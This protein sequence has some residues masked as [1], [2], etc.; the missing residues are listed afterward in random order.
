MALQ[1]VF[2]ARATDSNRGSTIAQFIRSGS[3]NQTASVE[4]HIRNSSHLPWQPPQLGRK[5]FTSRLPSI[6]RLRRDIVGNAA[7]TSA[8]S[9]YA[10]YYDDAWH[11][12]SADDVQQ[13]CQ[14]FNIQVSN[15][16]VILTQERSKRFLASGSHEDKYTFFFQ[17]TML[18]KLQ[19]KHEEGDRRIAAMVQE[20]SGGAESLKRMVKERDA[21]EEWVQRKRIKDEAEAAVREMRALESWARW[22]ERADQRDKQQTTAVGLKLEMERMKGELE[23]LEAD[24]GRFE[25][26][27]RKRKEEV[28]ARVRAYE[29][30]KDSVTDA[31]RQVEAQKAKARAAEN[32][33]DAVQKR[34][35]RSQ[36]ELQRKTAEVAAVR[37]E[38]EEQNAHVE[39]E[40]RR[41]LA[42]LEE[43]RKR[44]EGVKASLA[45]NH[46]LL[47]RQVQEM[48]ERLSKCRAEETGSVHRMQEVESHLL[49]LRS[50]QQRGG[51]RFGRWTAEIKAAIARRQSAFTVPPVGP[52][53]DYIQVAKA[54]EAFLLAIETCIR[55]DGLC[56]YLASNLRDRDQLR[57]LFREVVGA[58]ASDWPQIIVLPR[59]ATKQYDD[60]VK[61]GLPHEWPGQRRVLDCIAV[62]EPWVYNALVD[63]REVELSLVLGK[64][65]RDAHDLISRAFDLVRGA[66]ENALFKGLYTETG[67]RVTGKPGK[68]GAIT[69]HPEY[70]GELLGVDM[71]EE[72]TRLERKKEDTRREADLHRQKREEMAGQRQSLEQALKRSSDSLKQV[73]VALAQLQTKVAE[74]ESE[75][76]G[77]RREEDIVHLQGECDRLHA[78]VRELTAQLSDIQRDV[79]RA[80]DAQR[81]KE[82]AL[83]AAEQAEQEANDRVLEARQ[84][85][86]QFASSR[87]E[88][89]R[90]TA[91]LQQKLKVITERHSSVVAHVKEESTALLEAETALLLEHP[92]VTLD[93]VR[94]AP[95]RYAREAA[96]AEARLKEVLRKIAG[97]QKRGRGAKEVDI[98]RM[99]FQFQTAQRACAELKEKV[100]RLKVDSAWLR[101]AMEKRKKKWALYRQELGEKLVRYYR[102]YLRESGWTG[103][104]L[105]DH[106][107]K[108]LQIPR[109][110]PLSAGQEEDAAPSPGRRRPAKKAATAESEAASS[111]SSTTMSG[112]EK[113]RITVAF[114]MALWQSVDCPWRAM[115]EF[116]VFQDSQNRALSIEQLIQGAAKT[117][118]RQFFFLTPLDVKGVMR[119][120][121]SVL[122]MPS[123]DDAQSTLRFHK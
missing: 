71:K 51:S 122:K 16:C 109:A 29:E 47:R 17:A 60:P 105:I 74:V 9:K 87:D 3:A 73:D 100:G 19:L 48:E 102:L 68:D 101:D 50:S 13:L 53:G 26:E 37:A 4:V 98:E 11:K 49:R 56:S 96:K 93:D 39:E 103:D 78:E 97:A 31:A 94:E 86:D 38:M 59:R 20:I 23:A 72:I 114:L 43:E 83:A 90:N 27:K 44:H 32:R 14:Y 18:D 123:I 121:V 15:P 21:L 30:V 2:G 66:K 117:P 106:D 46:Q 113:S 36:R 33:V 110:K 81:E 118:T 8:S 67:V 1:T 75:R 42:E 41:Q 95:E 108:S 35:E 45:Q 10:L 120:G 80:R 52:L 77:L 6:I 82:A 54:D 5:P 24:N 34:L 58:N 107:T 79:Q 85:V 28:D 25:E 99:V 111:S 64:Q 62:D 7:G 112:G 55:K 115:D 22:K 116:D 61:K 89:R 69:K 57:K 91:R 70:R 119:P 84:H 92:D 65:G 76:Q 88:L 40:R 12:V 104:L 63:Q